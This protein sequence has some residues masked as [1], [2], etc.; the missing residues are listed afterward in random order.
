MSRPGYNKISHFLSPNAYESLP[1]AQLHPS[2]RCSPC[3]CSTA[4]ALL[5]LGS[6]AGED[7]GEA[8]VFVLGLLSATSGVLFLLAYTNSPSDSH[9]M[10]STGLKG[11]SALQHDHQQIDRWC[12]PPS[13]YRV[14]APMYPG[15]NLKRVRGVVTWPIGAD[16]GLCFACFAAAGWAPCSLPNIRIKQYIPRL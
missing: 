1:V 3:T 5:V 14:S 4:A 15:R 2:R 16:A 7:A 11:M 12:L 8:R 6:T 10:S 9:L 13:H